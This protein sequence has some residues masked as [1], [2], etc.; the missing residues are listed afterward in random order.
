MAIRDQGYKPYEGD[1]G[2]GSHPIWV[3]AST[4]AK[5]YWS[6]LR[7]KL[8]FI[9]LMI[10]PVL[11]AVGSFAERMVSKVFGQGGGDS[12]SGVFE[13]YFGL[14]E[15][16]MLALM[17]A[18]SGCGVVADDM[19]YRTIQLYF[20]KP[21]QKVDYILGKFGSLVLI[22][23][24]VTLLPY[25]FIAALR[26]LFYLPKEN[27]SDVLYKVG[28]L[29]VFNVALVVLFSSMVMAL[30]CLTRRAG[31]VVLA[32]LGTLLV[33]SV[34]SSVV[35]VVKPEADWSDLLS[36]AG[37]LKAALRNLVEYTGE[38][39]PGQEVI[40][41]V[42]EYMVWGPWGIVA[43]LLVG[44]YSIIYWRTSKLEGIA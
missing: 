4:Y 43:L 5:L 41:E 42:P 19:R 38:G 6:H 1:L 30:S 9:V 28:M 32:W 40:A 16:W 12:V 26:I 22:G 24:L 8:L 10:V 7:T 23:G 33:P 29:G 25:T 44:A 37:N 31:Y 27:F 39:V 13:Y 11:F 3:I 34:V 18:A 14:T 36:I 17:L 20:S 2:K 35:G 21:I 15:V